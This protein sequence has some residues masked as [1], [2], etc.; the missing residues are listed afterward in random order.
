MAGSRKPC[1]A[2]PEAAV[3]ACLGR[4]RIAAGRICVALSGG[5]DSVVL[6]HALQRCCRGGAIALSACH[7]DH[8]LSPEAGRWADFC[9]ELCAR[10]SVPCTLRRV[11]VEVAGQGLEAAA[12]T[13][14]MAALAAQPADFLAFAHHADDQAETLLYRLLRGTGLRGAAAMAELAPRP[15]GAAL[16]RPLL[17]LRRADIEAWARG[18]GLRWIEDESNQVA[19]FDRNYIRNELMPGMRRRF[20][21]VAERLASAA[22]NFR[23]GE[24]LLD[25]LAAIDWQALGGGDVSAPDG[26]LAGLEAA[27]LRNLLRWR[28]RHLGGRPPGRARLLEA[29]RQLGEAAV[30]RPLCIDLGDAELCRYRGHF[31]L[32]PAARAEPMSLEWHGE[33]RLDWGGGEMV[34]ARRAGGGLSPRAL[35]GRVTVSPRRDGDR[36]RPRAGGPSRDFKSLAQEAGVPP[37]MRARLPVLRVDGRPCWAAELGIDAA[38]AC[39]AGEIGLVPS[40]RAPAGVVTRLRE[41]P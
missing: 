33:E 27:R 22:E 32:Q 14:R 37:W 7:V 15:G 21:A 11:H 24:A 13:A 2:D 16:L 9:A 6:L 1:P 19:D 28:I 3:R 36:L 34:F 18:R 39:A 29:A 31:W 17:A 41:T 23:E 35:D 40:W 10:L 4:H 26:A 25:R 12:R 8:G 5:V 30:E 38:A 20:P